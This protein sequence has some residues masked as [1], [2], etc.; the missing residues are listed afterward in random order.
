[1]TLHFTDLSRI[2]FI[3]IETVPQFASFDH[4]D[5]RRQGLWK[6]KI[7]QT[8]WFSRHYDLPSEE[9]IAQSY[10]EKS[11]I[12]AEFGKIICISA[13][14]IEQNGLNIHSF[15]LKSFFDEDEYTL[16]ESFMPVL[17]QH[18]YNPTRH[19]LCGHNLKEFDIPFLCRRLIAHH[20]SLPKMI[21][22]A[23]QK[24]WQTKQFIDTLELWKFGDYKNYTSLDLIAATLDIPSP[25]STMDG[26]QVAEVYYNDDDGLDKIVRY[27][28]QDV[29][30]V[31]R[32]FLAMQHQGKIS[33]DM[34][35]STTVAK[36]EIVK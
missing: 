23:G 6:K 26:S 28:E 25:K 19:F 9:N 2:L 18:Y 32:I 29:V 30:T 17:M 4:L 35:C 13:G 12:Y 22:V 3:D 20:M 1:M 21:D 15:R 16:L 34:I 8:N 31:A 27:C 7:L 14:F 33:E 24:P 5:K 10:L 11:G 36:S